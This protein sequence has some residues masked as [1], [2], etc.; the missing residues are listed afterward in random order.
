MATVSVYLNFAGNTEAAFS[1][2]KK[3]FGGEFG[4]VQRFKDTGMDIV[5][6]ADQAK[7]MHMSL[8]IGKNMVLDGSDTIDSMGKNSWLETIHIL[9]CKQ[10]ARKSLINC[11]Q[12]CRQ[13]A[14]LRCPCRK[15]SGGLTSALSL[16]S[17]AS[18]G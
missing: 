12:P 3:V 15:H 16:I 8:P 7:I 2:Y 14:L 5:P 13:E 9:C 10:R 1:F 17:S 18:I 11:L 4:L 6:A